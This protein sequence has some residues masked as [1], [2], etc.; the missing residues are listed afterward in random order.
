MVCTTLDFV[1]SGKANELWCF[2]GCGGAAATCVVLTV[3][4]TLLD[5]N[6]VDFQKL[7]QSS[8]FA[9]LNPLAHL[10]VLPAPI[11]PWFAFRAAIVFNTD[12]TQS[13]PTPSP[14]NPWPEGDE[15]INGLIKDGIADW[16]WQDWFRLR[17]VAG[18]FCPEESKYCESQIRWHY[19]QDRQILESAISEYRALLQEGD[20]SS[21]HHT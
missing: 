13:S 5:E 12:Y 10:C 20:H 16:T 15:L 19:I 7:A 3:P 6:L 14:K 8:G 17:E 9:Y 4:I 11:G 1:H 18:G 21:N 2:S